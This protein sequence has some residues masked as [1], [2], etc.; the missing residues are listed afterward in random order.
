MQ[1]GI[2]LQ[3]VMGRVHC[4]GIGGTVKRLVA[5]ASLQATTTHQILTP[6]QLFD[7]SVENIHGIKFFFVSTDDI[8]QHETLF[9][10]EVRY[11]SVKTIPETRS[12]HSFDP[13]SRESLEMR[14]ISADTI[15]SV[16]R[17]SGVNEPTPAARDNEDAYQPGKYVA[18]T[19]D[20]QWHVGNV[21]ERSDT[22]NNVLVNFMKR[23]EDMKLQ[24][25]RKMDRCWVPF[26]HVLC[27]IDVPLAEGSLRS[28]VPTFAT[29]LH[30][31]H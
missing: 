13:I 10:L 31:C 14:R 30:S 28:T 11:S 15:C 6:R 2:F 21:V 22:N 20:N 23:K 27:T 9:Q 8:Q 17:L 16:I 25:P 19:Y 1:N 5:Q 26:V 4:D 18:C 7:W 29:G 3:L 24:W 12:H